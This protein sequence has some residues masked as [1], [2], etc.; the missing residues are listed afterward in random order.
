MR[1]LKV[2]TELNLSSLE[3]EALIQNKMLVKS[4]GRFK[5]RSISSKDFFTIGSQL[6]REDQYA[7][8]RVF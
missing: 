7:L 2:N 5:A 4:F 6:L 1:D 3:H 8:V